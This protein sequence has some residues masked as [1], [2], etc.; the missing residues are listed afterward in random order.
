MTRREF[1]D[2]LRMQ[3]EGELSP[4]QVEGHLHYYNEYIAE[5]VA[6]GKT[7][8]E[9]LAELGSPVMIAKTLLSSAEAAEENE[10]YDSSWRQESYG[11]EG[12][13]GQQEESYEEDYFGGR[14]HSW[15]INPKIL[16]WV[17]P[18]VIGIVIFVLFSLIGSL[19]MLVARFFI[20]LL[21]VVFVISLFK[22]HGGR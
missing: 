18:V 2:T 5:S 19:I 14:M 22:K 15:N 6:S 13:F 10:S 16:K 11:G 1:L 21:L 7:E 12:S 9:V 3:L 17:V 8:Q 20:P 4:A